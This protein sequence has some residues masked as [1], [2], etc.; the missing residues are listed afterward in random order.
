M[1]SQAAGHFP[2]KQTSQ[3]QASLAPRSDHPS[4]HKASGLGRYPG[5]YDVLSVCLTISVAVTI[6]QGRGLIQP[7]PQIHANHNHAS[8]STAS[9][10]DFATLT[11]F[12][13]RQP[14]D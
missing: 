5:T 10:L 6:E 1:Q 11:V 13:E 2:Y 4:S 3:H 8:W 14:H 9:S 12:R 7:L